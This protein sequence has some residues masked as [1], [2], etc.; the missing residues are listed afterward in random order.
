VKATKSN[1]VTIGRLAAVE[2]KPVVDGVKDRL[3]QWVF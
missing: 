2:A 3:R 1:E